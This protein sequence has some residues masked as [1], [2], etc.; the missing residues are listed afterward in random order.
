M[1]NLE[2]VQ[3]IERFFQAFEAIKEKGLIRFNQDFIDKYEIPKST[4]YDSRRD[5]LSDR[6]QISW[7]AHLVNDY[8]VSAEWLFSGKGKMFL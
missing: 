7:L 8:G 1:N 2:S 5:Y 4:F 3:I 6:F